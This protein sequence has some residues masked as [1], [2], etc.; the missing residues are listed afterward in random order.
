MSVEELVR[1]RGLGVERW[2]K[3]GIRGKEHP[4]Q[5]GKYLRVDVAEA[6]RVKHRAGYITQSTLGRALN[7]SFRGWDFVL[8]AGEPGECW[9][10]ERDRVHSGCL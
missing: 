6:E 5:S 8:G 2:N 7:A 10:Q 3:K 1:V 4:R 9:G